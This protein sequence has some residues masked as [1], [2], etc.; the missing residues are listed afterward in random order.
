MSS[1]KDPRRTSP[2]YRGKAVVGFAPMPK[3]AFQLESE[4]V[5]S[6]VDDHTVGEYETSSREFAYRLRVV[7]EKGRF[8][9]EMSDLDGN[10]ITAMDLRGTWGTNAFAQA[11]SAFMWEFEL[12]LKGWSPPPVG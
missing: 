5:R 9:A 4:R 8:T 12:H 11:F 10:L 3:T 2:A 6:E 7:R 1:E